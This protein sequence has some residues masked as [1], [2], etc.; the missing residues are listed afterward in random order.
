ML[1][2]VAVAI[3]EVLEDKLLLMSS[4]EL[5]KD[6]RSLAAKVDSEKVLIKA[7]TMSLV[8]VRLE[9]GNVW[10]HLMNV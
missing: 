10:S 2:C 3:M 1:I 8:P 5:L 7:L 9:V 6:F 4:E